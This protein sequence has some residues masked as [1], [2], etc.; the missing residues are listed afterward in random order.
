M[1]PAVVKLKEFLSELEAESHFPTIQAK[2]EHIGQI[3]LVKSAIGQ[4]EL[5]EKYGITGSSLV[6]ILPETESPNFCYL[7]VHENESSNPEHW[8]EVTF[9]G[10]QVLLSGGDLIVRK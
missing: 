10:E 3:N 2:A 6:N 4:L 1:N 9:D 5:C 8:E 7:T